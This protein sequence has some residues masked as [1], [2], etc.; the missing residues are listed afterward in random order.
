MFW[1]MMALLISASVFAQTGGSIEARFTDRAGAAVVAEVRVLDLKDGAEVFHGNTEP[2]GTLLASALKPGS[3]RLIAKAPGFRRVDLRP[4]RVKAGKVVHLGSFP[5]DFSGCDAPGM[6]CSYY[7]SSTQQIDWRLEVGDHRG[8]V[9]VQRQCGV[10]FDKE[11]Q[12]ACPEPGEGRNWLKDSGV[13]LRL[14]ESG[15]HLY[16]E[17]VNGAAISVPNK[18][19]SRCGNARYTGSRLLVDNL[20]AGSISAHRAGKDPSPTCSSRKR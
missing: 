6:S 14:V 5:M 4:V 1:P 3:Y 10:D 13:D 18:S 2:A 12:L 8:S 16:L 15:G 11:A 19:D 9:L 17:A 20:G 7:G